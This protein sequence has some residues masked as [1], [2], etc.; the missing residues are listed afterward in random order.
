MRHQEEECNAAA[1]ARI[2]SIARIRPR[3]GESVRRFNEIIRDDISEFES[4][5]CQAVE[6]LC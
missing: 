1:Q 3:F 6:S 4:Y 2:V 5:V